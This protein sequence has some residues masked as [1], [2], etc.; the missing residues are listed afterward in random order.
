MGK[1]TDQLLAWSLGPGREV[2][3]VAALLD[4][5][6]NQLYAVRIPLERM[7]LSWQTLHPQALV[8]AYYWA[9]TTGIEE[10]TVRLGYDLTLAYSTARSARYSK[11]MRRFDGA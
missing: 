1:A 7:T 5:F 3:G 6:A 8:A 11:V 9:P 4:A 2:P 10:R